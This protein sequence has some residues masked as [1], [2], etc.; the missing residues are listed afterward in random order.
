M[1]GLKSLTDKEAGSEQ[2]EE[3]SRP[4]VAPHS[5][6][7]GGADERGGRVERASL[8]L[9][10]VEDPLVLAAA[11]HVAAT[12]L[13]PSYTSA[14]ASKAYTCAEAKEHDEIIFDCGGEFISKARPPAHRTPPHRPETQRSHHRWLARRSAI[15][16]R[17]SS[18]VAQAS[19]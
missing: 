15:Y 18:R 16:P 3:E 13:A 19:R 1:Q 11:Q 10:R 14:S 12:P 2:K 17:Q 8:T 6:E 7:D 9:A 5:Q 4:E